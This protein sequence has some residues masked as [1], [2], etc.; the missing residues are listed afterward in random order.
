MADIQ[1][2]PQLFKDI[3]QA[4]ETQ[5]PGADT[6]VVMQYLA[7]VTGYLLGNDKGMEKAAKDQMMEELCAFS[8]H[9]YSDLQSRH[10]QAAAAPPVAGNAF[11]YWNPP[12]K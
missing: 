12:K 8:Q 10:Q 5:H 7:A 4:V 2:S 3:Q 6:G 9:V 1:L 11:G